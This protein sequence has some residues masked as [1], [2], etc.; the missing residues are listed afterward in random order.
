MVKRGVGRA[1]VLVDLDRRLSQAPVRDVTH[2]TPF[3]DPPLDAEES[4]ALTRGAEGLEEA[5]GSVAMPRGALAQPSPPGGPQKIA[6]AAKSSLK[7]SKRCSIPAG[8]KIR[9]PGPKGTSSPSRR[10]VPVPDVTT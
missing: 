3:A 1:G 8:T 4:A 10:K 5:V 2:A 9:S 6:Q 7:V